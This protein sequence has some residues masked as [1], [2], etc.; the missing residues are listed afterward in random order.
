M[1]AGDPAALDNHIRA[2]HMFLDFAKIRYMNGAELGTLIA[3]NDK[4]RAY[5]SRLTLFKRASVNL[6]DLR[7]DQAPH[8]A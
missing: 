3:L 7:S 8:A 1:I 2:Q 6:G 4:V 5:G